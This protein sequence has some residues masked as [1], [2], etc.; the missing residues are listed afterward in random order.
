MELSAEELMELVKERGERHW[1][2]VEDGWVV[3]ES[4]P[5]LSV[6]GLAREIENVTSQVEPLRAVWVKLAAGLEL[7]G[8]DELAALPGLQKDWQEKAKAEL[9]E[10]ARELE[11]A[12]IQALRVDGPGQKGEDERPRTSN[13]FAEGGLSP[14]GLWRPEATN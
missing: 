12:V 3:Q 11:K 8:E 5:L 10:L 6:A 9:G 14:H 1:S 13:L 2:L 7:R 4:V